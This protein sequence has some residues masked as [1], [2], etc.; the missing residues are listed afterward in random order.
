M[1]RALVLAILVCA[2]VGP[3]HAQW[4]ASPYIDTNVVGDVETGRGGIGVSVGYHP[5]RLIGFEIDVERHDHFF[6]D[7]DVASL[8]PASGVDLNTDAMLVMADFVAPY[9]VHSD[10]AGTWCPYAVAG[11]G[12]IRAVFDANVFDPGIDE[13]YDT[14]QVNVAFNAG[15]GVMHRLTNLVGIR[16]D[17]RY[18]HALV[19]ESARS[20]GYYKDYDFV[21]VS[22]GI[23]FGMPGPDH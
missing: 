15:G 14:S 12:A 3:A 7:S 4:V 21:R 23:T 16:V 9:C 13:D 17:L 10:A 6:N 20:G 2:T 22:V 18:I 11:L 5:R 8:V 19:D 1:R